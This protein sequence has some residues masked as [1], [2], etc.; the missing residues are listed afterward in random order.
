MENNDFEMDL[1]EYLEQ[2]MSENTESDAFKTADASDERLR[3]MQKKLP[4]WSL[5]PPFGFMR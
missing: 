1:G 5:E 4:S 2:S 3:E